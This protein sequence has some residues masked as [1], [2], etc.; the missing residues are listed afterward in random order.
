[1]EQSSSKGSHVI[2]V[3]DIIA[4][5]AFKRIEL[6]AP[7]PGAGARGV[8]N[9]GILDLAPDEQAYADYLP[10][11]FIV[12]NLGFARNDPDLMEA[13]LLALI[14]R[15]VAAVAVKT[16]YHPAIGAAVR[17]ASE[18]R[19]VPLYL[20]EG[21]YHE[22]VAY[23]ALDLIRRDEEESDKGRMVAGLLAD[24]DEQVTRAAIYGLTGA[25]GST[26]QCF[27]VAPRSGD[28]CSLYAVLDAL[29]G[30]LAEFKRDWASVDTAY[31]CRYHSMLLAFVSYVQPPA[32]VR[33]ASE[34]DLIARIQRTG[35]VHVGVGEEGPLFD[36]DLTVQEALAALKTARTEDA[37]VACWTDLHHDAFRAVASTSRLFA[38]TAAYH[39]ALLEE[40]D[41][42]N[43]AEL[44]ATAEALARAYG[45]VRHAAEILHQHP[46]TVRYRLRKAKAVLGMPDAPDRE[47]VF[48]LGLVFLE[49]TNPLEA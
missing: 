20:Y 45:D 24:H 19:G 12:S 2:T 8:R 48:L 47:F 17:A 23:Q 39:R 27:A 43:G 6:A 32:S 31:A 5:P 46:N 49:H 40:H 38:R 3:A 30:V 41:A 7:C 33:A 25:M 4:L 42:A 28:E 26:L 1:M 10:G 34:A 11:E 15:N 22:V 21:D 44:A 13:S 36:G 18:A 14:A 16:V 37:D 29:A 35:L 9:V